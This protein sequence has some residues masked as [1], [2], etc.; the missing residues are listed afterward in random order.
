M[1]RDQCQTGEEKLT[2]DRSA[3]RCA[4]RFGGAEPDRCTV[5]I[6]RGFRGKPCARRMERP[7]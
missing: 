4:A 2:G 5:S 7:N 6:D 1:D 3:A